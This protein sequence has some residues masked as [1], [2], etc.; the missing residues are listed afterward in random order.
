MGVGGYSIFGAKFKPEPSDKR[1]YTQSIC[2]ILDE[3]GLASS[4]FV[5]C[6][7]Q[8]H[9][10]G[11]CVVFG[12]VLDGFDDLRYLENVQIDKYGNADL[13]IAECFMKT[14]IL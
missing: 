11:Q 1:F 4:G 6:L 7:G 13:I 5:I 9:L 10:E 14:P 8:C 12:T 3:D 2:M